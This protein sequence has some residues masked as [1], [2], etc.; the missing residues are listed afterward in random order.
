MFEHGLKWQSEHEGKRK[1]EGRREKKESRR[2]KREGK[3]KGG[4]NNE[5]EIVP[6]W[7]QPSA[8]QMHVP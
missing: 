3:W 2:S 1:K 8:L 5:D 6:T 7:E 4:G